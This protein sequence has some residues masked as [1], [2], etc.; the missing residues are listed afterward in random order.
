MGKQL[1]SNENILPDPH[2]VDMQNRTGP[3]WTSAAALTLHTP[4]QT[5]T[6]T[7]R[8]IKGE[9]VDSVAVFKIQAD[10]SLKRTD[11]LRPKQ[12]KEYRGVGY[13]DDCFLVAGQHDGWMTCFQWHPAT[14]SWEEKAFQSPVSFEK[15]VDI[16]AV[17][18]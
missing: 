7:S 1:V 8:M 11:V 13:V 3:P 6:A 17:A 18:A 4:S 14:D 12:G 15:V 2:F 9:P 10:G 5:M 16:K